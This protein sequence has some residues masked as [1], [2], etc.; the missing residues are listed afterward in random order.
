MVTKEKD[1]KLFSVISGLFAVTL[2]VSNI[3]SSGK[4]I[5]IGPFALPGGAVVFPLSF[6]FGDI[7]TEVYGFHRSRKIIWTGFAGLVLAA[8]TFAIVQ[9]LPAASFWNDQETY[10]KILGFVPRIV[11]ASVLAYLA[12]EFSNSYVLSKMKFWAKGKVGGQQAWRFVASTIVGEGVD[13]LVF[14]IVAFT[15]VFSVEDMVRTG[16][17]LYFFKVA[18]EVIATPFSTRFANWVKKYE[19]VDVIDYPETTSYNPFNIFGANS[20][21]ATQ[22]QTGQKA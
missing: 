4:I 2:I 9:A 19:G 18:Y 3:A 8:V 17:T 7:L 12:G 1:L 20:S 16:L 10:D 11:L 21:E 14:M 5:A 13:S 6:I 22:S 15:G